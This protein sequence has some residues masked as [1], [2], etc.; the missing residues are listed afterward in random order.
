LGAFS[1]GA[2]GVPVST[3]F[4]AAEGLLMPLRAQEENR[5]AIAAS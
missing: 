5:P 3:Y 4:L 2:A 1:G